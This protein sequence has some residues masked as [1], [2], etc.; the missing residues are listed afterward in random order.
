[1]P[2]VPD[3]LLRDGWM[4]MLEP[5]SYLFVCSGIDLVFGDVSKSFWCIVS[6][7]FDNTR[8][9]YGFDFI[10]LSLNGLG[11]KA[12]H[13][14]RKSKRWSLFILIPQPPGS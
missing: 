8:R 7:A 2:E 14:E 12:R 1:M 6:Y 4:F 10:G 11:E 5:S 13:I 3:V 9:Y